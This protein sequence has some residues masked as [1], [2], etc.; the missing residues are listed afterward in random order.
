MGGAPWPMA[1]FLRSV[2]SSWIAGR[3]ELGWMSSMGLRARWPSSHPADRCTDQRGV[4]SPN[5]WHMWNQKQRSGPVVVLLS[6]EELLCMCVCVYWYGTMSSDCGAGALLLSIIVKCV[7]SSQC[8]LVKC[9]HAYVYTYPLTHAYTVCVCRIPVS[10]FVGT[11][12]HR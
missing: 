3:P 6:N 11:Y 9:N 7:L 12:L 5:R 10:N 8:V 4:G 2:P 1:A